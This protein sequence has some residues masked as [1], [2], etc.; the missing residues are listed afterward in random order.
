M[1]NFNQPLRITK[2]EKMEFMMDNSCHICGESY[3]HRNEG[4]KDYSQFAGRYKGSAHK[5]C[6]L[7]NRIGPD[8]LKIPVVF[9]NLLGY[10]GHFIMQNI[11]KI[12]NVKG[13]LKI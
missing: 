10:D 3:K 2:E 1:K 12:V 4:F 13:N 11:E 7:K 9:H 5:K 8:N 6:M